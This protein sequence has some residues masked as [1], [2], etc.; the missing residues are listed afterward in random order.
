M[1][2]AETIKL[3]GKRSKSAVE[4]IAQIVFMV[5]AS[6]TILAV[7]SILIYM[8]LNG[9]PALFKVGIKDILFGTVWKPTAVIIP[10]I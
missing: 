4:R 3:N 1:K 9:T 6:F 2:T 8:F 10:S 5:C 7:F